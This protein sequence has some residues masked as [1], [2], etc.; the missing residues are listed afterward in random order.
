VWPFVSIIVPARNEARNLPV[1]LPSLL[2]QSYP[3]DRYEIIVVDDNS[4]DATPA[5][6]AE[7]AAD[8][9]QLRV[10]RGTPLPP[11]WKGKPWAMHQGAEAARGAWLL[12][13]DADTRHL[14]NG[15]ASALGDA[16]ERG[17][18]LYTLAPK[19]LAVGPAERLIMP[20][21]TL[22]ISV[23]FH[24][25]LVNNPRSAVAIANGQYLLFRRA[26]YDALGGVDAVH[27]EIAED[28]E[29]GRLVKREGYKLCLTTGTG[30]MEVRMYQ[31]LSEVWEG[32]RK[33][34]LLSMKREP[35]TG[36]TQIVVLL[37]ALSVFGQ[38]GWF[39]W[40]AGRRG[41]PADRRAFALALAGVS[42]MFIPKR[43]VDRELG[44]PL[45][46]TFTYPLGLA[47]FAAILLDSARRLASGQGVTWKGRSYTD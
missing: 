29:L 3:T 41:R 46:W 19:L 2:A 28:L 7:Y 33:N 38:A 12:F 45:G 11:G 1:L 43:L 17:I 42:A 16:L 21:T 37:L 8:Y 14:P 4:T 20:V 23:F 40:R 39:G 25:L 9:P 13:T 36:A 6:L 24:P 32:W 26:V 47:M 27:T 10:I 30:I 35:L 5:I 18:D 34:V 15:L 44:L 22:G 31:N